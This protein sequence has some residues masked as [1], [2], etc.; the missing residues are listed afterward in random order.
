[1]TMLIWRNA[2][3]RDNVLYIDVGAF[4]SD[5]AALNGLETGA[6]TKLLVTA[7]SDAPLP[8]EEE[9]LAEIAGVSL[10]VWRRISA[11]VLALFKWSEADGGY[12]PASD[13]AGQPK[14]T[15]RQLDVSASDW[16][17]LRAQVFNRDGHKCQYCGDTAGPFEADHVTP[18]SRGGLSVLENLLTACKPCNRSKGAT[19]VF[20]WGGRA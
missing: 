20:A 11:S 4:F 8:R 3:P 13:H 6:Y 16:R 10:K 14:P 1:M 15:G 7:F 18:H 19:D 12:I 17:Q 9:R 5:T 2:R